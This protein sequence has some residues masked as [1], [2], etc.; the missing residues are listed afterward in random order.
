[1]HVTD[2]PAQTVTLSDLVPGDGLT[3][4]GGG[5]RAD[6]TKVTFTADAPLD[7]GW[8]RFR[9]VIRSKDRFT[10]HKRAEI[11]F[12]SDDAGKPVAKDALAWNRSL[13]E[14]FLIDLPR[15]TRRISLTLVH[16]DG[17]FTLDRFA[18]KRV[19]GKLLGLTAVT[20]K[21]R[22][23]AAYNCLRPVLWR[24]GGMLLRGKF[25]EFGKKVL[26]GLTDSRVMRV[27]AYKANEV[28]ASWW[29]RHALPV[30]EAE[31]VR[32]AVDAMPT[33]PPVAVLL[34]VEPKKFD[35]ARAAA[36]SVRRQ[37]YP[38]WELLLACAGP[39]WLHPHLSLIV[40]SDPRVKVSLVDED[41]GLALAVARAIADTECDRLLVLPQGVELAEHALF[42]LV[43]EL[44][45]SED[46]EAVSARVYDAEASAVHGEE[47]NRG[48]VWLT[49]TRHLG[50]EVPTERTPAAVAGWAT[51]A[52]DPADRR[53]LDT[54]LA[55]P[56][57]ECPFVTRA[58]V[59]QPPE[60][61]GAR[62]MIAGDLRG[63]T[64]WDH[65]TYAILRGLPSAGVELR[66]HPIAH[67]R[68]DLIPP[69]HLPPLGK[70]KKG[71]KVLAVSPPFIAHRFDPDRDTALFT[72]WETDRLTT[73]D[74]K[75]LNAC[76]LVIVP[77]KWQID[78]FRS[79]G[80]HVPMAVAPLGFDQLVYH[81]D[82][83][84]P[85]V[86]TFGTAGALVAGGLRKNAQRMIDLFRRAFP[87]QA[88]VRLRV[89]T[90]PS[91]PL[92]EMYDDPRID[93]VRAVLP[94]KQLADWYRS[95]TAYVNGSFGE[96]FGLHLIEAMACGRP[97]ITANYSGLTAFF[98]PTVGYDID[99][100]LVPV[101][102]EI[103]TGRWA[104]PGDDAIVARMRQ[105]YADRDEA[106]RL[107]E[108][109]AARARNFTWKAAGRQ[110]VAALR[111]HGFI[112]GGA[113]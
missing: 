82:G 33:P 42:H 21:L 62:L 108:L 99:H 68:A 112:D 9:L 6:G 85:E 26:K 36:H 105:V 78:C 65:V 74:V 90:S 30:D 23:L 12:A 79:S 103:Y 29:R 57:E 32:A 106:R 72:M 80:V 14:S 56:V 92:V 34:T 38:H 15:P 52:V 54:V 20:E 28:D 84:F 53:S 71:D 1:M 69:K 27:G 110:L 61:K 58:R 70:R 77:S 13:T 4:T 10:I 67:I 17:E 50:D 101:E 113:K 48:A 25:K 35:Q 104:E 7:A 111:E 5:W 41:D 86:C 88:D 81:A 66:Q 37:I 51:D 75:K 45:T 83:S 63:I 102:N 109:S 31:K 93:L 59:G 96:G 95:L 91:S 89:K 60:V 44:R 47:T 24:G 73:S 98:D 55:Y 2:A 3:R 16:A 76:G 43:N 39:A 94:H 64:G 19:N 46:T 97:L 100:T 22:L 18:V 87:T 11:T 8:Y 40:G 49:R 107:G